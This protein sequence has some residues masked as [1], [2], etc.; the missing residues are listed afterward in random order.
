MA[1]ARR[2]AAS[3][4]THLAAPLI[5]HLAEELRA[6]LQP[7]SDGLVA[8]EPWPVADA[9]LAAADRVTIA[10]QVLGKLRGTISIAP[11]MAEAEVLALA[12]D[13]PHVAPLL[14][15]RRIV[16]RIYVPGRIVNF[17]VA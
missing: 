14:D 13:E 8:G 12:A 5:P 2:E 10:V 7:G 11:D 6:L 9:A 3:V 1:W 16:K 15:G 4:A 17:V